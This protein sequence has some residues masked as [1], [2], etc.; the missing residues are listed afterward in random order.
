MIGA[1]VLIDTAGEII[2]FKQYRKDFNMSALENYRISLISTNEISNC[3][4]IN[5]LDGTSF[6][7]FLENDI[8][9]VATVKENADAARVFELLY[10]IPPIL[11]KTLNISSLNDR[12]VRDFIPDIIEI[13]D[14]MID[15]GYPQQT[16]SEA[17][18]VLTFH[19]KPETFQNLTSVSSFSSSTVPW[20]PLNIQHKEQN[21]YVDV[22]EKVSLLKTADGSVLNK[23]IN[24]L[25]SMNAALN[26]MPECT[27]IFNTR[28]V[29][30]DR[31]TDQR[32][33]QTNPADCIMF[34]EIAFHQCV[35]L[36]KF[37]SN[38]EI[39]FIPPDGPFELMKYSKSESVQAPFD[40]TPSVQE[41]KSN[42]L[43]ISILV[44]ATYDKSLKASNFRLVIPLPQ[45]TASVECMPAEKSDA[46]YDEFKNA[47]IWKVSDF[48]GHT[49]SNIT[50]IT[51]YLSATF[52]T[53]SA[54]RLNQPIY[55]E[56]QIPRLSA[57]GFSLNVFRV[58]PE[59][60]HNLYIRYATE[61]GKFQI[62]MPMPSET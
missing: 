49:N 2:L 13:L 25:T 29:V 62:M 59:T 60:K 58:S 28:A 43:K 42:R 10:K 4:P 40:V 53:S 37:Q 45:N 19:A 11:M 44:Y 31:I 56:F 30:A 7:H 8:Y 52:K 20:R 22:V 18:G 47:V 5:Y 61:A 17:L 21:V 15:F 50:I 46:H 33:Q 6:L 41:L 27:I 26:D 57:S 14:E 55:A 34:D 23:C 16:E 12:S 48:A 24:G 32:M 35:R 38:K 36:N 54:T 9:Y 51:Q 1:I 39:T 3:P